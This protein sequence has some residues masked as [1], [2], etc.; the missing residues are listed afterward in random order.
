MGNSKSFFY[1]SVY[2]IISNYNNRGYIFC[3]MI[4]LRKLMQQQG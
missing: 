2:K 1:N 3:K 4:N